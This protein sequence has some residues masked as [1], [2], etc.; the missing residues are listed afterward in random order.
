MPFVIPPLSSWA[1]SRMG[2]GP[3][4]LTASRVRIEMKPTLV[5][6]APGSGRWERPYRTYDLP[7]RGG[8]VAFGALR[9][10]GAAGTP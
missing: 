3:E 6:T 8:L 2:T 5:Q 10:R 9:G 4:A 1:P 7:N